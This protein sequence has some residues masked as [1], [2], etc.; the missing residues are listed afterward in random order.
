MVNSFFNWLKKRF[1]IRWKSLDECGE[2]P[3]IDALLAIIRLVAKVSKGTLGMATPVGVI[4][5]ALT[6][7]TILPD[8]IKLMNEYDDIPCEIA[9]LKPESYI[10]ILEAIVREFGFSIIDAQMVIANSLRLIRYVAKSRF[11]IPS[12]PRDLL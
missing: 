11:A 2:D 9:A 10:K 8:L 3:G 5:T 4:A 6:Y 1:K 7:S 12:S